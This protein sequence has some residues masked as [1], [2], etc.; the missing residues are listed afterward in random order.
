MNHL[1]KEVRKLGIERVN[2]AN[3]KVKEKIEERK[4]VKEN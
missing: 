2:I 4:V 3:E 1:Q